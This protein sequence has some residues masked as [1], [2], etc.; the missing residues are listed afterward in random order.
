MLQIA[1]S[2]LKSTQLAELYYNQSC[3]RRF[4]S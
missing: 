2:L 3:S 4:C 1:V